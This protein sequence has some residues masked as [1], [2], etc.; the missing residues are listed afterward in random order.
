VLEEDGIGEVLSLVG[1]E[2]FNRCLELRTSLRKHKSINGSQAT[3]KLPPPPLVAAPKSHDQTNIPK[4]LSAFSIT[5]WKSSTISTSLPPLPE[6]LDP[7]LEAGAFIH[8]GYGSRS[9][10]VTDLSYERL[11]WIGDAYLYLITT[12]LISQTFP[13]LL[14][15]KCAQLRERCV[16]NVQLA[17]YARQY[18]FDKRAKLPDVHLGTA[19]VSSNEHER[20][21]IL[22]DIFEAYIAAVVL[23]DP[24]NGVSR[25][26]EWLKN[27]LGITLAKDIIYEERKG[28]K[29]DSPLWRLRGKVESV[30]LV[31]SQPPPPN[32]KDQLRLLI[33][34]KGVK[35]AYKDAAPERK[36]PTNKLALFTVGVYLDGWGEKDKLLGTGKANGKKDAGFKAAEMALANTKLMKVYTEKKKIFDAQMELERQVLENNGSS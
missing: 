32:P 16:K 6:V 18:G 25:V 12:L 26:S 1:D 2:T 21:K 15:G 31:S 30:E 35:L 34:A 14:P 27:L 28:L 5:P 29:I 20:V 7:T 33:G 9:G 10:A 11:E 36:D 22:G 24:A 3:S 8:Q 4:S 19:K 23:S 13:S 17:E